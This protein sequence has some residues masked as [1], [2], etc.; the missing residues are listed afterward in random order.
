LAGGG[1]AVQLQRSDGAKKWIKLKGG[2]LLS[3]LISAIQRNDMQKV[4]ELLSP[5]LVNAKDEYNMTPLFYAK[6]V[7]CAQYLI[8]KGAI[9]NAVSKYG[10]K[11]LISAIYKGK[12]MVKLLMDH[13]PT[14]DSLTRDINE[15]HGDSTLLVR[16][17]REHNPDIVSLLLSHGANVNALTYDHYTALHAVLKNSDDTENV[18]AIVKLLL[19][20]GANVSIRTESLFQTALMFAAEYLHKEAVELLLKADNTDL[21][22]AVT[23]NGKNALNLVS[24]TEDP[25]DFDKAVEIARILMNAGSDLSTNSIKTAINMCNQKMVKLFLYSRRFNPIEFQDVYRHASASASKKYCDLS[26]IFTDFQRAVALSSAAKIPFGTD[27]NRNTIQNELQFVK[28]MDL[29]DVSAARDA[30]GYTALG[31]AARSGALRNLKLLIQSGIDVRVPGNE[32]GDS[33]QTIAKKYGHAHIA[34]P[35][36]LEYLL[37]RMLDPLIVSQVKKVASKR[38]G[39]V[40]LPQDTE[41]LL[42]SFLRPGSIPLA[43]PPQPP[44]P[45]IKDATGEVEPEAKRARITFI[46]K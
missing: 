32:Q 42:R 24:G 6:S 2:S 14:P 3:K 19:A 18:T 7:E 38:E 13:Y 5:E 23:K 10:A 35:K 25:K 15:M 37:P 41:R 4:Q 29:D 31:N 30:E 34:D 40:I 12:G 16:A 21:V 27:P 22:N 39:G 43:A 46:S 28:G 20:R 44:P 33:Y 26:H 11:P 1:T 9:V 8:D 45:T 17:A 36:L